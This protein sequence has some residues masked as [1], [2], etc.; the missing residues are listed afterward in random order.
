MKTKL[1]FF[2]AA[3]SL[4][5]NSCKNDFD[6]TE[7]WKEIPVIFGLLD[8][9]D[10]VHYVKVS[11]A[12][13]GD[14]NAIMMAGTY[15][16]INYPTVIDV[17]INE[18]N[19]GSIINTFSLVRDTSLGKPSGLFAYPQQVFYRLDNASLNDN[20]TYEL[21]V[22]NTSTGHIC[23]SETRLVKNFSVTSPYP[24]QQ[25]NFLIPNN[26]DYTVQWYSAEY[27]RR[28]N[29]TLRFWYTEINKITGLVRERYKDMIFPDQISTS[30]AGY[31]IMSE[32]F[33]GKSFYTFLRAQ[34]EPNDSLWRH[35]GKTASP[36]Q[37]L[38]FIISVAGDE[39][40]TYMDVNQPV[41]GPLMEKP[42]YTNIENGIGLFSS[43]FV[44]RSIYLYG[45]TLT[46]GSIDSI[47]A[48]QYT[49]DLNFCSTVMSSP[50]VCY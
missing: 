34:L 2:L 16:S 20:Y 50:Y 24:N 13:L 11:K 23:R 15:D 5:V 38:D 48:G 47:Y 7:D 37:Q 6:V 14:G 32:V 8:Q 33:K 42:Y 17:K 36:A 1:F 35:V 39:F 44:N 25:I 26:G 27:G 9:G 49:Y 46:S 3:V 31:E 10:S 45:R 29:L 12:F 43:R 40:A 41:D 19:N 18:K 22:T 4:I 28:Y 30:I 21:V